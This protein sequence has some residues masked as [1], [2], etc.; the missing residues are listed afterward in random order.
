MTWCG[1]APSEVTVVTKRGSAVEIDEHRLFEECNEHADKYEEW[2]LKLAA[3]K[4]D[5]AYAEADL[6]VVTAEVEADVRTNPDKYHISD[7][8]EGAIKLRVRLH[9]RVKEAHAKVIEAKFEVD[10]TSAAVKRLEHRKSNLR[11]MVDMMGMGIFPDVRPRAADTRR[12]VTEQANR[13]VFGE[14]RRRGDNDD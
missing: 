7:V 11:D 10:E 14:G 9:K 3:A 4:R 1:N 2:L 5:L 8:K 13:N 12:K 6:D